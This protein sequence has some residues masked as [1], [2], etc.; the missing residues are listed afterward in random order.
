MEGDAPAA[1]SGEPQAKRAKK[2]ACGEEGCSKAFDRASKLAI[3]ARTHSVVEPQAKRAQTHVCGEEGCGKAFDCASKL[4]M[5]VRKHTGEKPFKCPEPECQASFARNGAL[6]DHKRTHTGEKPFKCDYKDCP[7]TFSTS[8]HLA[9]HKRTHTGEKPFKCPEPECP[10]SFARSSNLA[11]HKRTHTGEKP[12]KCPAPECPASFAQSSQLADHKRTHTGE[13]PFA[14]THEGC[15]YAST[16]SSNLT[17][18]IES[19]HTARGMARKKLQEVRVEKAL[20]A[21]GYEQIR[22]GDASPPAGCFSRE[23]RVTFGCMGLTW[24][25]IDFVITLRNGQL[26]LL[27][28]DENQHRFG[29]GEA[30]CDMRRIARVKE[31]LTLGGQTA[32]MHVVRYN[33]Q[34]FKVAGKTVRTLKTVREARLVE[35]LDQF[36]QTSLED[37]ELRVWYMYYD[38]ESADAEQPMVCSDPDFNE[39]LTEVTRAI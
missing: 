29:Y 34:G 27:E 24:A 8:S 10:A 32:G 14:C 36:A 7:A 35:V 19:N 16:R 31:S 37:S 9:A 3:H 11:V 33:P 5:H 4:A 39:A 23:H 18:H 12:F 30:G 13:K 1:A 26:V 25:T 6:A 2:H 20:V 38:L 28:V 17:S 22:L 21:A 15:D